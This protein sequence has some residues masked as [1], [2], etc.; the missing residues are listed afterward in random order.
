M[1]IFHTGG[2]AMSTAEAGPP[3]THPEAP[4]EHQWPAGTL[5]CWG[6]DPTE[7]GQEIRHGVVLVEGPSV[8]GRLVIL[9]VL[10]PGA[11]LGPGMPGSFARAA[12]SVGLGKIGWEQSRQGLLQRIA[13]LQERS[14]ILHQGSAEQRLAWLLLLVAGGVRSGWITLPL[15]RGQLAAFL[16]VTPETISRSLAALRGRGMLGE[17]KRQRVELLS[18]ERLLAFRH[19]PWRRGSTV[20]I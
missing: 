19:A 9:E 12:T 7:P 11:V 4:T 18:A 8:A 1:Q 16:A 6:D 10:G 5:I 15:T 2:G 17:V 14:V 20:S 3:W 13:A